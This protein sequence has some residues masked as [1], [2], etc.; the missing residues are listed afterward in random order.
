MEAHAGNIIK[1]RLMS[2]AFYK[3]PCISLMQLQ[4]GSV[5]YQEYKNGSAQLQLVER[6][7]VHVV[8]HI[9]T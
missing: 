3:T 6:Y 5:Q 8:A 1:K 4:A 7:S 9:P 2:F